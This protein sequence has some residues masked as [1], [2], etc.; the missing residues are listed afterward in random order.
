M[1]LYSQV[2]LSGFFITKYTHYLDTTSA[3]QVGDA[4]PGSVRSSIGY[5]MNIYNSDVS[6]IVTL[7][8]WTVYVANQTESPPIEHAHPAKSLE[9]L[10]H[11]LVH[12]SYSAP[13]QLPLKYISSE[14][15][16]NDP[17]KMYKTG[18]RTIYTPC[19]ASSVFAFAH[20]SVEH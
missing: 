11:A 6:R 12:D 9:R 14:H 18:E 15:L 7:I 10:L 16:I 19:M 2:A 3:H 17:L 20:L 1:M 13:P 5:G 8:Q 4:I